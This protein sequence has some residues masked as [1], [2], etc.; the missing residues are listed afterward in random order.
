MLVGTLQVH[1][2]REDEAL[3]A[4]MLQHRGV[5]DAGFP[6]HVED[7][8]FGHQFRAAALL[9]VR[10]VRKIFRRLLR[11]P[12]V[13]AFLVEQVD[14]RVE[15]FLGRH[16]L[17]ALLALEH[18]DG[19]APAALTRDAPVRT[20]GH[21]GSDAVDGPARVEG[22]IALDGIERAPAQAVFLHGNEPLVGGAEDDRGVAAPAMR[23][24]VVDLALGHEGALLAQPV[25]DD[26]IRVVGVEAGKRAG[27]GG[28]HAVVIDG[29]ENRDIELHA[30]QVVVLAVAGS[31][32]HAT[33]T[34]IERD[35]V[36][37][38]DLAL[39][40]LADGAGIGKA[41]KIG[42]LERD[43]LAFGVAYQLI[44]FPAGDFGDLLHEFLRENHVGAVG[45]HHDVVGCGRKAYGGV[46][47]K[48]PRRG[49]PDEHVGVAGGTGR[50]EDARH[51]IELE[52]HVNGR[53][54]LV[55]VFDFG[56]GERGVALLA[57]MDGL[58]AAIDLAFE[59][60]VL[61]D[62]DIAG[63]EVGDIGK[64]RVIPIGVDAEALKALALD[65]HVLRGP[66]ATQ[67]AQLGLAGF[68]HLVGTQG[69]LD[70]VLDGLAVAVPTGHVGREITALRM[71]F[72][73]EVLDDLVEG[74]PDMDGAVGVRGAVMQDERLAVLVLLE[75]CFV[76]VLLLPFLQAL[77]LGRGQVAA[78][79]E[80]RLREI[81]RVLVR[82][83][84]GNSLPSPPMLQA[85]NEP[86]WVSNFA[87]ISDSPRL[88][89]HSSAIFI[90][91]ADVGLLALL[92]RRDGKA[93]RLIRQRT[94]PGAPRIDPKYRR[95]APHLCLTG[96]SQRVG[97]YFTRRINQR[98]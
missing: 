58:A 19:H 81:H 62:L 55:A 34:G 7:V 65:A 31:G 8:L 64:I 1:V 2:G 97:L 80:I 44:A 79:R 51:G 90:K 9:A 20:V 94:V 67:P 66:F 27:V 28:E 35:V 45:A 92:T 69:H 12:C 40:V 86:A 17:A 87:S 10:G 57:P 78:H 84:H 13:G 73:H 98:F 89:R 68:L 29:H 72:V 38:D 15:G 5:R 42:A 41:G 91:G 50:L 47:R 49:R 61:E 96:N 16:G 36:A 93:S 21:H 83:R 60:H 22:H 32:V 4:T 53:G 76:D 56:L 59:V 39:Q 26:R 52:L 25:D 88:R 3:V 54:R 63:L 95:F 77:R 6:P 11:E 71:A 24:A 23:I 37:V 30:D 85:G 46:G 74:M 43:R 82:V 48:R 14:D 75:H 33:G 70:H 18:G